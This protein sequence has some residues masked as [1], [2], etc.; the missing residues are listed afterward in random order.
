[1][2]NK[3]KFETSRFISD[4]IL[5]MFERTENMKQKDYIN[6]ILNLGL[7]SF[8]IKFSHL[9]TAPNHKNCKYY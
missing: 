8:Q 7:E 2:A 9:I 1:M 4:Q 6:L 3:V 5:E